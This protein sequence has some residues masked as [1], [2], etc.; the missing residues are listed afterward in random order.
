MKYYAVYT[1]KYVAIFDNWHKAKKYINKRSNVIDKKF[2]TYEAAHTFLENIMD[3]SE[4]DIYR[5][6]I[7][8]Y[9]INFVQYLNMGKC[10]KK[11]QD[12]ID[13]QEIHKEIRNSGPIKI[14]RKK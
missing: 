6:D 14:T 4:F 12:I 1:P 9:H 10:S 3:Q 7:R 5:P 11:Y 13:S 8:R 2:N